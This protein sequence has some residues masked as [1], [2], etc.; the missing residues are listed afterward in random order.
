MNGLVNSAETSG[1]AR[2]ESTLEQA[3][4]SVHFLKAD[5]IIGA[6]RR[7]EWCPLGSQ[8]ASKGLDEADGLL[9]HLETSTWPRRL[10]VAL[11][12]RMGQRPRKE[13]YLR[14]RARAFTATASTQQHLVPARSHTA[15]TPENR[16]GRAGRVLPPEG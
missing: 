7:P 4:R 13:L 15:R 14:P 11:T 10:L 8:V 1:A 6:V 16:R 9:P 12:P 5:L 2:R 3:R